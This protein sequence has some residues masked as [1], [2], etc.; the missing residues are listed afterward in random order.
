[1]LVEFI[2]VFIYLFIYLFIFM[3][4]LD[5]VT[6]YMVK[7]LHQIEVDTYFTS[8]LIRRKKIFNGPSN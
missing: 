6:L 1:M 5:I 2:Y 4:F 3:S 8:I 7:L